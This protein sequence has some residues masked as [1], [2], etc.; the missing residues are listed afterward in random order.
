MGVRNRSA[1]DQ[2]NDPDWKRECTLAIVAP[3]PAI[4]PMS[5]AISLFMRCDHPS[6]HASQQT[7]TSLRTWRWHDNHVIFAV[8]AIAI[9]CRGKHGALGAIGLVYPKEPGGH[10]TPILGQQIK[11]RL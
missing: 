11:F 8:L 6:R 7:K 1:L 5:S 4:A 2:G 3:D 10:Q 9:A